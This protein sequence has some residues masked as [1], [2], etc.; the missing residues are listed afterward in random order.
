MKA[1]KLY[2]FGLHMALEQLRMVLIL[3]LE[4][5]CRS[6][7]RKNYWHAICVRARSAKNSRPS[8]NRKHFLAFVYVCNG[9][10]EISN[11][12]LA[13]G[14]VIDMELQTRLLFWAYC[15]VL[16]WEITTDL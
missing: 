14:N 5:S 8:T 11:G 6:S 4:M 2:N 1:R 16:A 15:H 10:F 3:C 13:F 7:N 12:T 9:A